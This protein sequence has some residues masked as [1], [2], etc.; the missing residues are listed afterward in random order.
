MTSGTIPTH[1]PIRLLAMP[2]ASM[3][4]AFGTELLIVDIM[5]YFQLPAPIRVSSVPKGAQLRPGIYSIIE[6]VIAV[7]GSGGT[8]FR[9]ALNRRYEASH[10]FR[11]MLRRMGAFWAFGA[12]G[13]AV[14]LTILIF[15]IQDEAAYVVGWAAPWIW[16][17]VW[18]WIT[19]WYVK[20][21]LREEKEGWAEE[22]ATK[23]QT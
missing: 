22:I 23:S 19:I 15:T 17:G 3:L 14:V 6:D 13:M 18:V 7:D 11:S 8:D 9:E 16:A 1:P 2:Q 5:R 4:Y 10:V 21:K 20:R 12:Q